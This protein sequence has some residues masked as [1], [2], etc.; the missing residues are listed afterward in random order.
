MNIQINVI[1]KILTGENSGCYI[2]VKDDSDATGG[3]LIL[4]SSTSDFSDGFDN[5]VA[6]LPQLTAYFEEANWRVQ[7]FENEE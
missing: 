4:T 3:Y 7:W 1:G 5:W 2:K 6:N